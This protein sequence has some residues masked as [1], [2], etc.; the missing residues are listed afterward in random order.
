MCVNRASNEISNCDA[1]AASLV[2]RIVSAGLV[3]SPRLDGT[4]PLGEQAA[5]IE[6]PPDEIKRPRER[7]R[8]FVF[9][10]IDTRNKLSTR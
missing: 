1:L 8:E 9:D 6:A 3:L 10:K 4:V 2:R 7:P 5:S